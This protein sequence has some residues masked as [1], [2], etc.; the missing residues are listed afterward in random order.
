MTTIVTRQPIGPA[1]PRLMQARAWRGLAQR[2]P[3]G[4]VQGALMAIDQEA[5]AVAL[6]LGCR[7]AVRVAA[8]QRASQLQP[9]PEFGAPLRWFGR[10]AL[11]A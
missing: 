7:G 5:V 3:A 1:R 2:D 4:N 9:A 11:G 8:A 6:V 10:R